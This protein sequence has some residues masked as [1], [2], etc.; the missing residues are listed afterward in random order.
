MLLNG[1]LQS[2]LGG[3]RKRSK[4]ALRYLGKPLR[5]P[6]G[7]IGGSLLANP[8]VLLTAAGV[9]WGIFE[10]LQQQGASGTSPAGS[11]FPSHS[12]A[13]AQPAH[14][15]AA[16][17]PLPPLPVMG[18]PSPGPISE[19]ALKIVRLAISAAYADGA[20][21][22][23]ERAAILEHARSAGVDG[24]VEQELAQPRPLA[25]IV[26]GVSDDTQK[27]TLYVLAFGIVRG[28]EQPSGAERIYLATLAHLLGLDPKT[29][30]QLE[31]NAARR[32]DAEPEQ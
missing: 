8:N 22:D 6:L 9:A 28:D 23:Q 29:V 4:K 32:I 16:A 18:A 31:Q 11:G 24:I 14:A 19:P 26:A 30:Q 13:P 21:S 10:T 3:R 25:E 5:G 2:V 12:P 7:S 20:V 17:P 15:P 1:V 27:A